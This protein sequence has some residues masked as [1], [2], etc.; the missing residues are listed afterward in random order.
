MGA[1]D[2]LV[3]VVEEEAVPGFRGLRVVD[4]VG[5][6]GRG[7]GFVLARDPPLAPRRSGLPVIFM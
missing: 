2:A 3:A 6:I 7:A 4:V 1:S 5:C